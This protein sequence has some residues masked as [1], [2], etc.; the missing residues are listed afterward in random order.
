MK[1]LLVPF[2]LFVNFIFAQSE[3]EKKF[4]EVTDFT[5]TGHP[6]QYIKV[7]LYL[8]DAYYKQFELYIEPV[9]KYGAFDITKRNAGLTGTV[10][11]NGSVDL[12]NKIEYDLDYKYGYDNQ[13]LETVQYG[14][15]DWWSPVEYIRISFVQEDILNHSR[16]TVIGKIKGRPVVV[17]I[18]LNNKE[19]HQYVKKSLE[20][21]KEELEA[22]AKLIAKEIAKQDSIKKADEEFKLKYGYL[23]TGTGKPDKFTLNNIDDF[24]A[25]F[26][27]GN[28]IPEDAVFYYNFQNY[29]NSP[30]C[31]I[32]KTNKAAV[33]YDWQKIESSVEIGVLPKGKLVR[34][35]VGEVLIIRK[36]GKKYV[37]V[38]LE[39]ND[40]W[41]MCQK[42]KYQLQDR[43]NG[44]ILLEDLEF[45]NASDIENFKAQLKEFDLIQRN[46]WKGIK[47]PC[48]EIAPK[49]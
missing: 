6:K 3:T 17:T 30:N 21:T 24:I 20:P 16:L 22:K 19:L 49:N 42:P 9:S 27:H 10:S 36:G 1:I 18:N 2:L 44:R 43:I 35:R 38:S 13:K 12:T 25:N 31:I 11:R 4:L 26:N 29:T 15:F 33:F 37:P 47:I 41:W 7:K 48:E 14:P 46:S 40:P 34:V 45:G 39:L 32:L 28:K 8:E 23:F 5:V